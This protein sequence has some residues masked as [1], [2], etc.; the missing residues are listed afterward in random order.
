MVQFNQLILFANPAVALANMPYSIDM[1]FNFIHNSIALAIP[2]NSE[3][4]NLIM[5]SRLLS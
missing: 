2:G 1:L 5:K 3:K 4:Y